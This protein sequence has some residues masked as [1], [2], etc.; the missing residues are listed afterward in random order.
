M[1]KENI[2]DLAKKESFINVK[3][4][5]TGKDYRFYEYM[6]A[7]LVPDVK[8]P[9]SC[10]SVANNSL[11]IDLWTG[12]AFQCSYCHVQGIAEDI[13]WKTKKMR[14]K[15]VKRNKFSIEEIV[16][17]LV[18]HPFFEKDRTVLSIGTSSTEPFANGEVLESTLRIMEYFIEKGYKNP[19]WIVTKAGIPLKGVERLKNISKSSKKLIISICYA[20]NKK[21]IEPSQA[22]RFRNVELI[23]KEP[24]ISINWYLRP[25]NIDWFDKDKRSLENMFKEIS[26][27][28]GKFIDSLIPGGLRWT[29]GIEYGVCES[30]NLKLPELLKEN[31]KKTMEDY[32]WKKM[33]D[34]RN[35]YFP[36]TPFYRHSSCG[37]SNAMFKSNICLA[38][39]LNKDSCHNSLCPTEQRELCNSITDI[40]N[41]K[42]HII[43]EYFSDINFDV[44]IEDICYDN[45]EIITVPPMKNMTP[46]LETATI[47][48]ATTVLSENNK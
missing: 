6:Y 39:I 37:V 29:E 19:F 24:N 21:E 5:N 17:A 42:N 31:N 48:L 25:F 4:E 16:D 10:V 46:A 1:Y 18:E 32:I 41:S 30:R 11:S 28:Y 33:E 45:G 44:R 23:G 12:C 22:N 36:D 20:G 13:D 43:N 34:L 2:I 47:H 27:K 40:G 35:K 14:T 8:S 3:G 7:V 38:Q 15:P 9:L 26:L